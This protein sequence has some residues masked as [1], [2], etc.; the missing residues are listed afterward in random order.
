MIKLSSVHLCQMQYARASTLALTAD[1]LV[2]ELHGTWQNKAVAIAA[3]KEDT[4]MRPTS[5]LCIQSMARLHCSI[6]NIQL[7]LLIP[8]ESFLLLPSFRLPFFL[9]LF[10][11][12]SR[13]GT[14]TRGAHNRSDAHTLTLTLTCAES[15]RRQEEPAAAA[16]T[17]H[18]AES[19]S[20][21]GAGLLSGVGCPCQEARACDGVGD[22]AAAER[23]RRQRPRHA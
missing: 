11:A 17:R 18:R 16:P 12:P 5:K 2:L 20:Q 4:S 1:T 7:I 19:L 21:R 9:S 13:T 10:S 3:S 22:A 8:N 6:T 14:G 15:R 23:A